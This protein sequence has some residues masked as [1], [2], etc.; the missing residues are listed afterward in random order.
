VRYGVLGTGPVGQA[1]AARLAG[2]GHD[3]VMGSRDAANPKALE[4]AQDKPVRL[5][6]FA[7]AAAH[8][9]TVV[10]ATGGV[11]T[12]DVLAMAG[13]DNL[14]GKVLVDVSNPIAPDSGSPPTLSV[15][16]TDSIGEQ[17]QAAYPTARVVKSLN[18]I[19]CDVMVD[20]SLVPGDHVVFVAGDDA[21]AKASVAVMLGEF[22]WPADRVLDLGGIDAARATEMYLPLW[23]RLYGV[24]GGHL[25]NIAVKRG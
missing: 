1:I 6:T 11:V 8:G 15:A 10:N 12:L 20:P 9:E 24:G 7:E 23:I 14:A 18:T 5:A 22:G 16:N 19:N 21:G 2:L 25:F 3:V 17:V 13:A 4:W